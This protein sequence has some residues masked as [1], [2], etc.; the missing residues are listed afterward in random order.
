MPS[1]A[2]KKLSEN[3]E[4]FYNGSYSESCDVLKTGDT[5]TIDVKSNIEFGVQMPD[6]DWIVDLASSRGLSS[7][8]LNIISRQ[9]IV[10]KIFTLAGE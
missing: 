10:M 7:H 9:M 1:T 8:T 5:I 6:V 2:W 4:V 3:L